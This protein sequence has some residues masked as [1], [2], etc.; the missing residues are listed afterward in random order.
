MAQNVFVL[1]LG[2]NSCGK[3]LE[4]KTSPNARFAYRSWVSGFLTGVNWHT[5]GRQATVPDADAAVAFV[6]RYCENNPLLNISSAAAA[7][8]QEAGGPRAF[9]QWQK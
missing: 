1:G 3:W 4:G 2:S 5:T 7:L 8:V 6:D 9:H